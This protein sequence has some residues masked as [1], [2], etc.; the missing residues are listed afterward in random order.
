MSL[1]RFIQIVKNYE[2]ISRIGNKI[3]HHG[4]FIKSSPSDKV[5]EEYVKKEQLV[6]EFLNAIQ[7]ADKQWK[8]NQ[9][10]INEFWT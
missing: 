7:K 5:K 6:E 2:K 4:Q 9:N 8:N 1:N 3:I 10:S